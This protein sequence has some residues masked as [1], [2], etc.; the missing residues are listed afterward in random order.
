MSDTVRDAVFS[1]LQS[2][3]DAPD[4]DIDPI[5]PSWY[6]LT[7]MQ[8]QFVT[9]TLRRHLAQHMAAAAEANL[10]R[11]R[12][13]E[14]EYLQ[15]DSFKAALDALEVTNTN[16]EGDLVPQEPLQARA[17]AEPER[18]TELQ[19]RRRRAALATAV[20]ELKAENRERAKSGR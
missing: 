6:Q 16:V 2:L 18:D 5:V 19:A 10:V 20:E 11:S 14:G 8:R 15:A 9:Q 17:V 3:E 12:A 4:G 13:A 1:A 7:R